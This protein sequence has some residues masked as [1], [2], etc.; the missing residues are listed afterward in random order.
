MTK[1]TDMRIG[2]TPNLASRSG[3]GQA[4]HAAAGDLPM[5]TPFVDYYGILAIR[6]HAS[7]E[8]IREAIKRQRRTWVK[9]QQAPSAGRRREAEVRVR[10]IDAAEST[11]LDP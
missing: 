4:Q 7:P 1:L 6:K 5:T 2:P 3:A 8:R 9:R 11:L 10:Q